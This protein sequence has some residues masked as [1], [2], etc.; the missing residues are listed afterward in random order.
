M[1]AGLPDGARASP[2]DNVA[3]L[4]YGRVPIAVARESILLP[5][6]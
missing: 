5:D 3:M 2:N 4:T 6:F 1:R